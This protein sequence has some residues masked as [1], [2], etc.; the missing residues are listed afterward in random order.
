MNGKDFTTTLLV[1]RTAKETY[2]A[3]NNVR[4]WWSEEVQG[5]TDKLGGVFT[6][7][8]R[9]V[10]RCKRKVTELVPGKTVVWR[11]LDNYFDFTKDQTEWMG[12]EIRFDISKKG[13]KTA[14]RFT[15][16][17]LVPNHECYKV[18]SNAWSSYIS[19]SLGGLITE[20][21]GHPNPKEGGMGFPII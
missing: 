13:D 11:V 9:D 2:D 4:G 16:V 7:H 6:Y 20:G 10:H 14:I 8:Y 19:G 17:G 21:K 15:H 1:D 5:S 12:T 18:C 3:I